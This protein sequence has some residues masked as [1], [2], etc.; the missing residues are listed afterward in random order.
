[1]SVQEISILDFA[2]YPEAKVHLLRADPPEFHAAT[3]IPHVA[4]AW[5]PWAGRR[6]PER[7]AAYERWMMAQ[8]GVEYRTCVA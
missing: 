3:S 7:V 8:A 1:M 6:K 5:D 2:A 4:A